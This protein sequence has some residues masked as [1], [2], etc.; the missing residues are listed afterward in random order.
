MTTSKDNGISTRGFKL[1][2]RKTEGL[3]ALVCY[4][5]E[6]EIPE[7]AK[8]CTLPN[9]LFRTNKAR[10]QCYMTSDGSWS[11]NFATFS[12]LR[13]REFYYMVG[14]EVKESR[15][16]DDPT[17]VDAP[18]IYYY[19]TNDALQDAI[20]ARRHIFGAPL[21][22]G[23]PDGDDAIRRKFALAKLS[24]EERKLLGFSAP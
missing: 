7:D 1:V 8:R 23:Y 6:L 3:T 22:F 12:S 21:E 5:I 9:G 24:R 16:C 10:V 20:K 4:I 11:T 19:E 17:I 2:G 18:G 15:Y 13:N 14:C